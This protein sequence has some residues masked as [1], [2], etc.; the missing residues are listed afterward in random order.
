[1]WVPA[2]AVL[3]GALPLRF[4]HEIAAWAD[5]LAWNKTGLQRTF[6]HF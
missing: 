5:S 6:L 4:F 2:L 3:R 1:M